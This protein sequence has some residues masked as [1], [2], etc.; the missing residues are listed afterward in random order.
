MTAKKATKTKTTKIKKPQVETPIEIQQEIKD[1]IE[2]IRE[3][4]L[5]PFLLTENQLLPCEDV[6]SSFK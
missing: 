2:N 6:L 1:A 3:V 5:L 4:S